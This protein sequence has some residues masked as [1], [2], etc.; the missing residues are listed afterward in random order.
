MFEDLL[1]AL[2]FMESILEDD[3]KYRLCDSEKEYEL[4]HIHSSE[5][6]VEDFLKEGHELQCAKI[7]RLI[8]E[9][10]YEPNYR[11]CKINGDICDSEVDFSA[12]I[13]RTNGFYTISL[14]E[15]TIR[16][17]VS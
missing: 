17:Q 1:D 8:H 11:M 5:N 4:E 13:Y 2:D 12:V 9:F 7:L 6:K 10:C 14:S 16:H 15:E 3:V